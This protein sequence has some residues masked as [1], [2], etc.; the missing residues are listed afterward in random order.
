MKAD[1]IRALGLTVSALLALF[2]LFTVL[3]GSFTILTATQIAPPRLFGQN[4]G[5][6]LDTNLMLDMV[7]IVFVLFAAV[8]GCLVMLMPL[9]EEGKNRCF[10]WNPT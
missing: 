10:L 8:A 1:W 9:K 2:L 5:F 6:V 3:R 4:V 7:A